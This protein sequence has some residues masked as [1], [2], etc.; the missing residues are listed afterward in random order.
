MKRFKK[1]LYILNEPINEPLPSLARAMSLA[2][3]NQADLTVLYVLPKLPFS[4]YSNNTNMDEQAL[5][6]KILNDEEQGLKKW[7]SPHCNNDN[8]EIKLRIGKKY[9]ESIRCVLANNFDLVIKE[10]DKPTW[11]DLFFGSDDMHLLRK[12]PCPVWMMK[13]D[14]KINYDKIIAAVDFDTEDFETCNDE[15]NEII[16]DLASSLSISDFASEHVVNIYDVPEEGFISLWADNPE[17]IKNTLFESELKIRKN[18]MNVF[19]KKLKTKIGDET[20]NYLSPTP[21]LIQGFPGREIPRFAQEMK[22]D[23]VVMG[24]VARTGIAGVVIGNTAETVLSQ[25]QC[26]VL[27][28]K[29]KGFVSPVS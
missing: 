1:I 11:L 12:C 24:T 23:L 16:I 28:I 10:A 3:N 20:Y 17:K 9:M 18:K 8:T 6:E 13:K 22:A 7:L 14:E 26:S 27:A 21:H 5:K 25:L 2:K 19:L 15:L 4:Y 29:P